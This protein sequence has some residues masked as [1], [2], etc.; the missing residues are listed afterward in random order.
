[1]GWT[2]INQVSLMSQESASTSG[3]LQWRTKAPGSIPSEDQL[4]CL[5]PAP[6]RTL[7][8]QCRLGQQP[9]NSPAPR[10]QD[11]MGSRA[12]CEAAT[13][14]ALWAGREVVIDRSAPMSG[15]KSITGHL[16]SSTIPLKSPVLPLRPVGLSGLQVQLR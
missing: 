9:N 12:A 8:G 6:R 2:W 7:R 5:G 1:M 13:W 11:S 3:M 10:M 14:Q 15:H 16:K 4:S